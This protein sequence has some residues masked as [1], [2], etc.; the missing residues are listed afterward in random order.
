[1]TSGQSYAVV[2]RDILSFFHGK[3]LLTLADVKRY[4]GISDYRTLRRRFPFE[5]T[6]ISAHAL[7]NALTEKEGR[8]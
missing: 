5:G 4:T 3:R 1:M 7:A 2:M 8:P 6:T